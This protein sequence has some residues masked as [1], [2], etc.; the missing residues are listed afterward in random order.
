M[1]TSRKIR[2]VEQMSMNRIRGAL[3]GLLVLAA[4]LPGP[5]LADD[6]TGVVLRVLDGDTLRVRIDCPCCP[7]LLKTWGVRLLGVDAP[8]LKDKRADRA[9]LAREARGVLAELCPAGAAV[10]LRGYKADKF[11]GR[12]LAWVSC[13]GGPDA[14]EVLR[15]YGLVREYW[16][17]GPK[18]W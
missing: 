1:R 10:T 8:E 6:I 7:P 14:A 9:F 3:L 13:N 17:K 4:L 15:G 2:L 18:P 16:G 12:L 11:G 5:A